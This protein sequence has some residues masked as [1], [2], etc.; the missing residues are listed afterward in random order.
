VEGCVVQPDWLAITNSIMNTITLLFLAW[1]ASKQQQV[2][3]ELE[4]SE[5]Q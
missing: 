4:G 5:R 1:I 2:K 3:R